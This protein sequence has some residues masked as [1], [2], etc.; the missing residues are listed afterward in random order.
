MPCPEFDRLGGRSSVKN[1][2]RRHGPNNRFREAF[3]FLSVLSSVVFCVSGHTVFCYGCHAVQVQR[4]HPDST[5]WVFD[6]VVK[7]LAHESIQGSG[8]PSGSFIT[9]VICGA[10]DV[11]RACA[12]DIFIFHHTMRQSGSV[13]FLCRWRRCHSP[14]NKA[15]R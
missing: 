2:S 12:I 9:L 4:L 5:Q 7:I 6:S 14:C 15:N 1:T 11:P 3:F 8:V 10:L 13:P